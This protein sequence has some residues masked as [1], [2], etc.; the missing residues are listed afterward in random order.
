[1][2]EHGF[3]EA[4]LNKQFSMKVAADDIEAI[5]MASARIKHNHYGF[6]VQKYLECP[7]KD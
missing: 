5:L 1:L 3:Q 7:C 6:T 4:L 2:K